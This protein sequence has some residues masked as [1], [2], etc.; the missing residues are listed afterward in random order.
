[1]THWQCA[2]IPLNY[3]QWDDSGRVRPPSLPFTWGQFGQIIGL[4]A[5]RC[6]YCYKE[7]KGRDLEYA[8]LVPTP[9]GESEDTS[10]LICLDCQHREMELA[11]KD[12]RED[13]LKSQLKE[14]KYGY[15]RDEQ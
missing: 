6:G 2:G 9:D 14:E 11:E 13:D 15:L 12:T 7:Q 3:L 5:G 10:K 8:M 1:M 4:H